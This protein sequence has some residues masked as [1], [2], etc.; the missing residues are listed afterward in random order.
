MASYELPTESSPDPT[1]NSGG[2]ADLNR[3]QLMTAF[4]AAVALSA[5]LPRI[6]H[7]RKILYPFSLLGV[8][9]HEMGH[10]ILAVITPS[11]FRSLELYKGLGGVVYH[12]GAGRISGAIISAGGLLGPA[13]FGALI[14]IFSA[15]P[16]TSRYVLPVISVMVALSVIFFIR[17]GFGMAAMSAIA[18]VLI[19]IAFKAPTIIRVFVAQLIGIQFC[20]ASWGSWDYLFTGEIE[21][22]GRP[23]NSDTGAIEEALFLPYWFWGAL[24]AFLSAVILLFAFYTAWIKPFRNS[25]GPGAGVTG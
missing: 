6:P 8:W 14:I 4:W 10:A 17:N 20:L 25:D 23:A 19:P 13:F 24:I 22:D 11:D 1:E 2:H 3:G 15:R 12:A 18:V 21:I 7:G 5:V 16:K 9:A